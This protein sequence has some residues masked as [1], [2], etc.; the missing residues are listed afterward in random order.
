MSTTV[1]IVI[2]VG[3]IHHRSEISATR[4]LRVYMLAAAAQAGM[5]KTRA[6]QPQPRG[7][8]DGDLTCPFSFTNGKHVFLW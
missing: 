1:I 4:V 5:K 7:A 3:T 2:S 6:D 8:H